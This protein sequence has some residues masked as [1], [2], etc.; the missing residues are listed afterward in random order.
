[1][2]IT[3]QYNINDIDSCNCLQIAF[4]N[5][6]GLKHYDGIYIPRDNNGNI[7]EQAL[8]LA[9]N[10]LFEKVKFKSEQNYIAWS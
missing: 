5:G 10:E 3:F 9:I 2:N 7:D 1:M 6:N 4:D 8:T